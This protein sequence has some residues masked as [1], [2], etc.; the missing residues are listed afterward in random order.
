MYILSNFEI[1]QI[2]Q[3]ISNTNA[4]SHFHFQK[5]PPPP[6]WMVWAPKVGL[7]AFKLYM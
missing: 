7:L 3:K 2:I 5:V 6:L 1:V 4:N